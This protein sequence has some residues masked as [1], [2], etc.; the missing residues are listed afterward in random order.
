MSTADKTAW[1]WFPF[2]SIAALGVVVVVNFGFIYVALNSNPGLATK[3]N[4]DTSNRYDEVLDRAAKQSALGW[5]VAASLQG[6]APTL[7]LTDK[8]GH[9]LR[10]AS[11]TGIA[12]RPLGPVQP[13]V[14]NFNEGEDGLYRAAA[15]LDQPGQWELRLDVVQNGETYVATRRVQVR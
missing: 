11:V 10:H 12:Q 15:T 6:H 13:V 2:A 7:E 4:F 1:R 9:R 14:L 3:D 8:S 5:G